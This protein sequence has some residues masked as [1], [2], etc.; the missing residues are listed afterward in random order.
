[1]IIASTIYLYI[2]F[3]FISKQKTEI[4]KS[5][6]ETVQKVEMLG[7]LVPLPSE[8]IEEVSTPAVTSIDTIPGNTCSDTTMN[9]EKHQET[10]S[11]VV[12]NVS[13]QHTVA[14][15][16]EN[17]CCNQ[18]NTEDPIESGVLSGEVAGQLMHVPNETVEELTPPLSK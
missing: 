6:E 12:Q 10:V 5:H 14:S 18:L 11:E 3:A 16:N 8:I 4:G 2:D 9:S 17:K 15:E 1:M 13:V 7:Q